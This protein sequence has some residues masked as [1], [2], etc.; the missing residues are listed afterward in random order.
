MAFDIDR[1]KS[2]ND[3]HGHA[4]GDMVIRMFAEE[5]TNGAGGQQ[6]VARL[7][8]EE[9]VV[10]LT[11]TL[12]GRAE[13]A[14]A[15]IVHSFAAREIRVG[16]ALVQ[17]TVSAGIAFASQA[18]DSFELVLNLADAALYQAKRRGRNRVQMAE[19]LHEVETE[20]VQSG[21]FR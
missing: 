14:V 19:F 2:I 4:V 6:L 17:C 10:V 5:L 7:G 12:P 8:G 18:A 1:F 9:F 16:E 15:N 11:N 3:L 21:T 20:E 13:R